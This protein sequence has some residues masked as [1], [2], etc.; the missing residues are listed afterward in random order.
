MPKAVAPPKT[1]LHVSAVGWKDNL[2]KRKDGGWN[3]YV[4]YA[5]S[6]FLLRREKEGKVRFE[7]NAEILPGLRTMYLGGHSVCSQ[8][9]IVDTTDGPAI[10]ASDE[11]Y[12]YELLEDD[13]L[14]QIRTSEAK[15]RSA[16]DRLVNLAV[17]EKGIIIPL[18]DPIVWETYK[19]AGTNW[20]KELKKVSDRAI[21]KYL[22]ARRKRT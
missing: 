16:V 13:L 7:D 4:D 17:K 12:L 6:D 2:D 8:A 14:P 20:L 9:V 15:Y 21:E 5:F 22:K 19:R 11:V 1:F 3:S 10:L 18:H